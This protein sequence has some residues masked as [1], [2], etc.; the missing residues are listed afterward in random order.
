MSEH[1]HHSALLLIDLQVGLFEGSEKL[2][3]S[4]QLLENVNTLIDRARASGAPIFAVRHTGP[5]GSLIAAGSPW[6]QLYPL[7]AI[8]AQHDTIFDKY[9][10]SCFAGTKLAEQ[11][12]T[13]QIDHLV[14]A[15]FKTQ[16]CIDTNCR[17]AAERGFRVTLIADAHSCMNTPLLSAEVII[18]HHNATLQGPFA[19]LAKASEFRF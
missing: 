19:Q 8:D 10:P 17:A 12:Q 4:E 16:Y 11:L 6:W 14:I 5:E 3:R 13:L 15:G 18:A 2:Y 1:R 9:Q 7:I